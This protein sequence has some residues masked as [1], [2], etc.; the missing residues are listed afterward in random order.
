MS[1]AGSFLLGTMWD[2]LLPSLFFAGD[3]GAVLQCN[4]QG[5]H[6]VFGQGTRDH[7]NKFALVSTKGRVCHSLDLHGQVE[8]LAPLQESSFP[9]VWDHVSVHGRALADMVRA[10]LSEDDEKAAI[11]QSLSEMP[12][13]RMLPVPSHAVSRHIVISQAV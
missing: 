5:V 7:K 13:C 11:A 3:S 1:C 2:A 10:C 6:K 9:A 12:L 8:I 4:S